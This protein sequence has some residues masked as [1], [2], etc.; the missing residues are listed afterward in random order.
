MRPRDS[1]TACTNLRISS[2][3][4]G[5]AAQHINRCRDSQT[6]RTNLPRSPSPSPPPPLPLPRPC[7]SPCPRQ[8]LSARLL[9]GP[10]PHAP[11]ASAPSC[12]PAPRG[13]ASCRRYSRRPAA[14]SLHPALIRRLGYPTR[15]P[16]LEAARCSY[17]AG[18]WH[19]AGAG[20]ARDCRV[21]APARGGRAA[22]RAFSSAMA[23]SRSF[24]RRSLCRRGTADSD[25]PGIPAA[26]ASRASL[27]AGRPLV[28]SQ[29]AAATA[30]MRRDKLWNPGG[31]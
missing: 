14:A 17:L 13:F 8:P 9:P 24:L 29:A 4:P 15:I 18:T 3:H 11:S 28:A 27:Y 6:T 20:T 10:R 31:A 7:P 5:A 16:T 26:A 2:C 22:R 21:R 23:S 1:D 25:P 19:V 30:N 12:P